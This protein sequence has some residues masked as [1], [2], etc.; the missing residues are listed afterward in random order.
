MRFSRIPYIYVWV[1]QKVGKLPDAIPH[2]RGYIAGALLCAPV[3]FYG[4]MMLAYSGA[5][6]I[7]ESKYSMPVAY[8]LAVPTAI[9]I[10]YLLSRGLFKQSPKQSLM[11]GAGAVALLGAAIFWTKSKRIEESKKRDTPSAKAVEKI[12]NGTPISK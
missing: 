3:V 2:E 11:I 5:G 9:A 1:C 8:A 10:P 12:P 6:K 4:G 7:M